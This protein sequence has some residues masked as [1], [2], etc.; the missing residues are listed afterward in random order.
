MTNN[1]FKNGIIAGS[2]GVLILGVSIATAR[3]YN[4]FDSIPT[5][6]ANGIVS[7]NEFNEIV[8]TLGGVQ[9]TDGVFKTSSGLVIEVRSDNPPIGELEDGRIWLVKP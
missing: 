6:T 9:N 3:V 5:K 7:F 2:L 1:A 8:G 4:A